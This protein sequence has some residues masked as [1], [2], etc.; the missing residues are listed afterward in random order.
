MKKM[1]VVVL[2]LVVLAWVPVTSGLAAGSAEADKKLT[3]ARQIVGLA[4]P[5]FTLGRQRLASL[6]RSICT[7][8]GSLRRVMKA[9]DDFTDGLA[10][11]TAKYMTLETLQAFV[12]FY[13][14]PVGR[15]LIGNQMVMLREFGR[16][17]LLMAKRQWRGEPVGSLADVIPVAGLDP[18][19]LVAARAL[20]ERSQFLRWMTRGW[21]AVNLRSK[22][23]TAPMLRE[24][25]SR[26]VARLFTIQE[27]GA[28]GAFYRS[29]AYGRFLSGQPAFQAKLMM[30]LGPYRQNLH[31]VLSKCR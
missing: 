22:G 4:N 18:A 12:N 5:F 16:G 31:E 7:K 17:S 15:K 25:W 29:R 11:V 8:P 14:T 23:I 2:L 20:A 6:V 21:A 24:F 9:Y 30:S 3:L 28:L 1:R 10:R 26:L 13:W 27:I 19:R